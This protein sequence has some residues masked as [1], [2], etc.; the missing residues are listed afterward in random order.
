MF[1][2]A[3]IVFIAFWD[4]ALGFSVLLKNRHNQANI[5]FSFFAF[6][7]AIW[8]VISF[9][10]NNPTYD[11]DILY[12][13]KS[14]AFFIPPI[15]LYTLLVFSIQFTNY[16]SKIR[17]FLLWFGG[18]SAIFVSFISVTPFVLSDVKVVKNIVETGFGQL[19]VL[20]LAYIVS[21]LIIEIWILTNSIRNLRGIARARTLIM[22]I[23]LFVAITL[24]IITN[25]L[26]PLVFK[27]V[28]FVI[29]GLFSTI[30]IVGGFSYSIVKLRLFDIRL[31]VAR[32]IAYFL[33]IITLGSLY[34]I[35]TFWIGGIIFNNSAIGIQ[36]QSFSVFTALV[37]IFTFQPMR[38]FFE[39]YTDK[40]FYRNSYNPQ[41]LL[42]AIS[43]ILTS[44]IELIS[45][46]KRSRQAL[47]KYLHVDNVNIVVLNNN[48]VFT[49]SGHYVVSQ[50]QDLAQ[51]LEYIRSPIIVT[52]EL[53]E[54]RKKE[55]LNKYNIRVFALLK[56]QE[57]RVGYLLFGHKL[58]GDI[59]NKKDIDVIKT[60]SNQLAVAIQNSKSYVEVQR[61]NTTLKG[62]V[63]EATQKLK[64]AN[65]SL[66]K[67]DNVK[68][69]FITMASHQLRTPLTIS[70]N[71]M[72][73]ILEGMFGKFNK[74]QERALRI[75][76]DHLH[77]TNGIISDLLN[78]SR[79]EVGQFHINPSAVNIKELVIDELEHLEIKAKSQGVKLNFEPVKKLIPIC[80]L[81]K[82]K[83]QQAIL[84]LI[85][86]AINYSPNG[87][88]VVSLNTAG[89]NI[90]F[91]VTDNGMGIPENEL[92]NLFTKFFRAENARKTRPSG[93]GIGL[94]LVKRVVEDQGGTLIFSS[95]QGKGSI[96]GFR[97]PIVITN[98]I[99]NDENEYSRLTNMKL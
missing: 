45:L 81:D 92:P 24:L 56:T 64:D 63:S 9:L 23:S 55:L 47:S 6:L 18:I 54:G 26:L 78:V 48:K 96:F 44:E 85:D 30:I 98:E 49:E 97:I 68:D 16:K 37:L 74:D 15:G 61:F 33:L 58:S 79:M 3:V 71:F 89:N 51:D 83:T 31:V 50:L 99:P 14:A 5:T 8:M 73:S 25:L 91:K 77:I 62:K 94:Y 10:S 13:L 32:S 43:H 80:K 53:P 70:E 72:S 38:K 27:N 46:S 28:S 57:E 41:D 21:L 75:T 67:L 86:N 35:V 39:K 87:K 82:Q 90:I 20:Y 19:T 34:S 60:V 2:L 59:F 65:V 93:T 69:E 76:Q 42:N 66:Q 29:L 52:D 84:N 17:N 4:L 88:V 40:I 36:Q 95:T 11:L 1:L 12:W 7:L 22:T